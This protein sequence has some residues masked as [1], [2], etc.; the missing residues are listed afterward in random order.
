MTDAPSPADQ[1][2]AV[3]GKHVVVTGG[4]RG[5]GLMIARGFVRAGAHVLISAR[6]AD[7]L[8]SAADELGAMELEDAVAD[9]GQRMREHRQHDHGRRQH[10]AHRRAPSRRAGE[11]G[12]SRS[13][14]GD[15]DAKRAG[16]CRRMEQ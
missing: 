5:I 12:P 3:A 15:H 2:F 6:K 10:D 9:R 1:L 4:S 11:H 7:Q 14:R 8:T 16:A 13:Q